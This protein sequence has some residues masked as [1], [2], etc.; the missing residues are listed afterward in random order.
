MKRMAAILWNE[1]STRTIVQN[2]LTS[3][4]YEVLVTEDADEGRA[5]VGTGGYDLLV[6]GPQMTEDERTSLV[7]S[8]SAEALCYQLP[9]VHVST[10][11][12]AS[13]PFS[14]GNIVLCY[15]KSNRVTDELFRLFLTTL[16][17]RDAE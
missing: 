15:L 4:L 1:D 17:V 13:F 10:T 14:S 3:E 7:Q 11:L 8:L 9:V 16:H 6:I 12:P 2:V 5:H